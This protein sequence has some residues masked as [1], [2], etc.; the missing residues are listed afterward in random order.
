LFY[1]GLIH[2]VLIFIFMIMMGVD[3]RQVNFENVWL[4]P[5]RFAFSIWLFTWTYA[6]FSSFTKKHR[7]FFN[8]LNHLIALCMFIEIALISFQAGRGVASHF[9]V[10]TPFDTTIF[11]IMGAVIGFNAVILGVWFLAFTFWEKKGD[12]YRSSIIWGMFVFLLGNF[13][14]YLIIRYGWPT[15]MLSSHSKIPI[16]GWKE[17]MK[18]LKISHAI[19]LHAI[20]LLPISQLIIKKLD[21]NK[22][23]IH[24]VGIT[25]LVLYFVALFYALV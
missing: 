15:D 12:Y 23:L 20:Q 10:H 9:N 2:V 11:S 16:T 21:A 18:D 13:S 19:G 24:V 17:T 14:G 5:L 25:F 7:E 3:D 22:S 4:K 1:T 6:W 8:V